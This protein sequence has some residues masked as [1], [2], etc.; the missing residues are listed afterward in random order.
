[1]KVIYLVQGELA[2]VQF[3]RDHIP[4]SQYLMSLNYDVNPEGTVIH[5]DSHIYFPD[6]TW[7]EGRNLLLEKA[8]RLGINFDYYIFV[9]ADLRVTKGSFSCFETLLSIHRP[10]L[11]IPLGDQVKNSYRYRPESRVQSQFSFDQICQA[12]RSDVVNDSIC[13]PY[14]TKLDNKSWW[15]SCEINTYLSLLCCGDEILQFNDFEIENSRHDGPELSAMGLSNYKSGVDSDGLQVCR[16]LII[17]EFGRQ[18]PFL[19]TLFHPKFAPKVISFPTLLQLLRN[20]FDEELPISPGRFSMSIAKSM[21]QIIYKLFFR[22]LII[23]PLVVAK[24]FT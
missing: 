20:D 5:S 1:M 6:S 22:R 10:K 7:A 4:T 18:K 19:G 11:G 9:D 21:Q 14:N 17:S 2:D 12:Y 24:R 23:K 15:Y 8:K 13:L 16:E 3:L